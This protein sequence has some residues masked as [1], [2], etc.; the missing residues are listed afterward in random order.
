MPINVVLESDLFVHPN[1]FHPHFEAPSD[2]TEDFLPSRITKSL[3]TFK[4]SKFFRLCA[5]VLVLNGCIHSTVKDVF[6]VVLCQS[7]ALHVVVSS[8]P[9]CQPSGLSAGHW[10]GAPL[11]QVNEDIHIE[12]EVRLGP[13]QDDGSSRVAGTD[14]WDPFGGDVIEGDG[15]DQAEAQDEDIHVG[16]A[17]GAKMAKLLLSDQM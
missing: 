11:V 6:E 2:D 3:Q 9:V 14:L 4:Q 13:D 5:N 7:R 15:V 1:I 10:F 17:Q 8:D 12:A 16:I